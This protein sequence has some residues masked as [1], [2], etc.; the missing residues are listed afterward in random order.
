MY[1]IKISKIEQLEYAI[2]RQVKRGQKWIE[3]LEKTREECPPDPRTNS[4]V[5]KSVNYQSH[6]PKRKARR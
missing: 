5:L 4:K 2:A 1:R 3:A 6:K